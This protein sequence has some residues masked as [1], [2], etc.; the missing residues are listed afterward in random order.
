M[1]DYSSKNTSVNTVPSTHTF[2]VSL[3]E[4]GFVEPEQYIVCDYGCGAYETGLEAL[5]DAGFYVHQYDPYHRDE[6]ENDRTMWE[7]HSGNVDIAICANVLNVVISTQERDRILGDLAHADIALVSIYEGDRSHVGKIT[8]K[9]WQANRTMESYRSE[10][11][12]HF[13]TVNKIGRVFVCSN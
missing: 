13:G 6:D 11:E 2:L 4:A 9:G 10:L 7:L 1:P 5:D 12:Q 3:A 8:T